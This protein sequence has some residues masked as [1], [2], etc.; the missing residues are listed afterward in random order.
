MRAHNKSNEFKTM[1]KQQKATASALV[2]HKQASEK[3]QGKT[4]EQF[5]RD[6]MQALTNHARLSAWPFIFWYHP[7]WR[8]RPRPRQVEAPRQ[9]NDYTN[10]GDTWHLQICTNLSHWPMSDTQPMVKNALE[11]GWGRGEWNDYGD[12][13]SIYKIETKTRVCI[14]L[15][16]K[17]CRVFKR[18]PKNTT[19]EQMIIFDHRHYYYHYPSPLPWIARIERIYQIASSD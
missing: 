1:M 8:A 6:N 5:V 13:A 14:C 11:G 9:S 3:R 12:Y 17:A 10:G 18:W 7:Q 15:R 19:C 4:Y 16:F 2:E